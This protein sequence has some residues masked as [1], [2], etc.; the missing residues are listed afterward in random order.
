MFNKLFLLFGWVILIYL[1]S[2]SQITKDEAKKL[3]KAN[4]SI[5]LADKLVEEATQLYLETF[6]VKSDVSLSE[7]EINKRCKK[8]EN[9]ANKKQLKAHEYYTNAY[10]I[11]IGIYKLHISKFIESNKNTVNETNLKIKI[12]EINEYLIKAHEFENKAAK[13]KDEKEKIILL[14]DAKENR[15]KAY[16]LTEK[17]YKFCYPSVSY[18]KKE[19]LLTNN[20]LNISTDEKTINNKIIKED[21]LKEEIKINNVLLEN[22]RKYVN[23]TL[24]DIEF[25]FPEKISELLTYTPEQLKEFWYRYYFIVPDSNKDIHHKET[26]KTDQKS[27]IISD[28]I[29]DKNITYEINKSLSDNKTNLSDTTKNSD[30]KINKN[31]RYRIQIYAG[32]KSLDQNALRKIYYGNKNLEYIYEDGLYKYSLG[33]FDSFEAAE[34]FKKDAGLANAVIIEY[35]E[36]KKFENIV[37]FAQNPTFENLQSNNDI[38]TKTNYNNPDKIIFKIQIA[39]SRYRLNLNQLSKIY[40]GNYTIEEVFEDNWFKY[41]SIGIGSFEKSLLMLNNISVKGVFIA[42]YQ[43]NNRINLHDA[44]KQTRDIKEPYYEFHVQILASKYFLNNTELRK[45]YTGN[46]P[47]SIFF[48]DNLYKY[49]IKAGDSYEYASKIKNSCNVSDAFIVVYEDGIKIPSY[50]YLIKNKNK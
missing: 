43:G 37:T 33:D 46:Y 16:D 42:A 6:K 4:E 35:N 21:E 29:K 8:L 13:T 28:N 31:K 14:N 45:Y 27:L 15:L 18:S 10:D 5:Q 50:K 44:I 47:I 32:K 3:E 40:S 49:R 22:L 26:T 36:N 9:E 24:S 39:A 34:K 48:E 30:I 20:N 38:Q 25:L 17:T 11:I 12:E 19:E 23:D 2:Y 41:Q 7:K 1:Q